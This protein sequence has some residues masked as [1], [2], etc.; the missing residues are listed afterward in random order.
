M[1]TSMPEIYS[2]FQF[3]WHHIKSFLR[4]Y[5]PLTSD[6]KFYQILPTCLG[7]IRAQGCAHEQNLNNF[8]SMHMWIWTKY[9]PSFERLTTTALIPPGLVLYYTTIGHFVILEM[10]T[11]V[12]LSPS[13]KETARSDVTKALQPLGVTKETPRSGWLYRFSKIFPWIL[14]V[15]RNIK[16]YISLQVKSFHIF[17]SLNLCPKFSYIVTYL[18]PR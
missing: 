11:L 3:K 9:V 10:I 1:N 14:L 15:L 2:C 4:I 8:R 17:C 7:P 16:V 6:K 13:M 5:L 12:Q 18:L